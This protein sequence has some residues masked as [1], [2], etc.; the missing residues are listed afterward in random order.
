MRSEH[1]KNIRRM[2][3]QGA[4]MVQAD[5]SALGNCLMADVS[6]TGARLEVEASEALPDQFILLLSRDG[7]VRRQCSVAWR[8][9]NSVGIRFVLQKVLT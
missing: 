3:R 2:V 4:R 6:A 7:K 9:N 8:S 5:G 1:R